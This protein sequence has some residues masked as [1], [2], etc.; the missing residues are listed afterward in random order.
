VGGSSLYLFLADRPAHRALHDRLTRTQVLRDGAPPPAPRRPLGV[1]HR[2]GVAAVLALAVAAP[3][4]MRHLV[5]TGPLTDIARLYAAVAAA[6][7]VH[8][9]GVADRVEGGAPSQDGG[10]RMLD[11]DA[12]IE[13]DVQRPGALPEGLAAIALANYAGAPAADLI[14]IRLRHGFDIGV[15]ARFESRSFV[16]TPAQ[17]RARIA[18]GA[19]Q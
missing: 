13:G 9:A 5:R 6:P 14:A 1:G 11:I 12:V 4:D 10:V 16:R 18:S 2:F 17:W 19:A 15:A 7:G 3:L 8:Y